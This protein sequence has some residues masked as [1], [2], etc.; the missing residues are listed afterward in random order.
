MGSELLEGG[1]ESDDSLF[2]GNLFVT[3]GYLIFK[4]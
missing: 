2:A 1:G 3:H 4:I